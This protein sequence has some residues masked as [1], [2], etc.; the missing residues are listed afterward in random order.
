MSVLAW[1]KLYCSGVGHDCRLVG[2]SCGSQER[3]FDSLKTDIS[4]TDLID[5][6]SVVLSKVYEVL[7]HV[8]LSRYC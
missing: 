6:D 5:A 8:H 3:Y 2:G 4:S 7:H 1:P